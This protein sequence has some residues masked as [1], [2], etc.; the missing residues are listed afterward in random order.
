MCQK[1]TTLPYGKPV[2]DSDTK[3]LQQFNR[4][5]NAHWA[6]G[7]YYL[8]GRYQFA[9]FRVYLESYY[10]IAILIGHIKKFT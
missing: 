9:R 7:F 2:L 6:A 5:Y 8:T 10:R 1:S 4:K 3:Y